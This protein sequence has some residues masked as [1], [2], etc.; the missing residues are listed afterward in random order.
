MIPHSKGQGAPLKVSQKVMMAIALSGSC[1]AVSA[2]SQ[3]GEF[4]DGKRSCNQFLTLGFSD[5]DIFF[6]SPLLS[7]RFA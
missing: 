5:Q 3:S 1:I 7:S 4:L 6:L 2:P